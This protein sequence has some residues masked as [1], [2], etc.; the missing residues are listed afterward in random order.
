MSIEKLLAFAIGPLLIIVAAIMIFILPEKEAKETGK[1]QLNKSAVKV[2]TSKST[3]PK[4]SETD[5]LKQIIEKQKSV[6]DSLN[7]EL[8]KLKIDFDNEQKSNEDL[9]EKLINKTSEVEKAKELA[10]TF[11]SMKVD[12]M[13]PILQNVDDETIALIYENMSNRVR[14]NFLLALSSNRAAL[15]TERQVI[16]N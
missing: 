4:L 12:E 2:D 6:V 8:T 15:L 10:K 9:T 13:R 16:P 5:S 3:V 7:R 1:D 14:K 11:S